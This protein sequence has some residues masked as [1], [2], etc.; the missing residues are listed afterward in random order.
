MSDICIK[1]G[2]SLNN[3]FVSNI[4]VF[5]SIKYFKTK[6]FPELI[7]DKFFWANIVEG[8]FS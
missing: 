4:F 7:E 8:K 3:G 2:I 6:A 1:Y 5:S